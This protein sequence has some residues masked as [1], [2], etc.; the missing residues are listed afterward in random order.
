[1]LTASELTAMRSTLDA[2]L[3][4]SAIIKTPTWV[5]DGGGGG[6]T[7]YTASGTVDCRVTPGAGV[8]GVGE[9]VRGNRLDPDVDALFTFP[10]DTAIDANDVIELSG[11]TFSVKAVAEPRSWSVSLRVDVKEVT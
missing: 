8:A 3:P 6:T 4:D 5:S 7:T 2:S 1:M 9:V 10:Y 11:R